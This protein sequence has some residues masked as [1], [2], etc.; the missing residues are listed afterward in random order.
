MC[1]FPLKGVE[2]RGIGPLSKAFSAIFEAL[3]F[4]L[5]FSILLPGLKVFLSDTSAIF[6]L[7]YCQVSVVRL[8]RW[9]H[10]WVGISELRSA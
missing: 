7:F 5:N 9:I 2:I 1:V 8:R 4:E 6:K 10:V 3:R